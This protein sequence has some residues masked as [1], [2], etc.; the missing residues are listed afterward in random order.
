LRKE[1]DDLQGRI[2]TLET[3]NEAQKDE[4]KEVVILT[5]CFIFNQPYFFITDNNS[6]D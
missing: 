4:V 6:T 5:F 1:N 2:S 3:D